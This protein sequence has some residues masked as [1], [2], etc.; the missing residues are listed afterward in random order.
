MVSG[1]VA[2]L[3]EAPDVAR[4]QPAVDE[5]FG[6]LLRPVEVAAHHVG[7]LDHNFAGLSL[8][9]RLAGRVDQP[10][11]LTGQRKPHRARLAWAGQ[12]IGGADAR[13]LGRPVP[14]ADRDA[15]AEFEPCRQVPVTVP[16]R[17]SADHPQCKDLR[18][19][20]VAFLHFPPGIGGQSSISQRSRFRACRPGVH[21]VQDLLRPAQYPVGI[22]GQEAGWTLK[23][24]SSIGCRARRGS[25]RRRR[26]R[27]MS[28]RPTTASASSATVAGQ[29]RR[30][31]RLPAPTTVIGSRYA[32]L[33]AAW[34]SSTNSAISGVRRVATQ[35]SRTSLGGMS[36]IG[37]QATSERW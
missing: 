9:D 20:L 8:G 19:N 23:C 31:L 5:R 26:P 35:A 29:C 12:R 28:P 4:V 22:S 27:P 3:V 37:A 25:P 2:V 21:P 15:L 30:G 32:S 17:P 24:A 13:A 6:G 14:L 10:D 7:A 16:R 1:A 36:V 33:S 18:L 34:A 11:R